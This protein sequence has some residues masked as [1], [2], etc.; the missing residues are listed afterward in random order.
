MVV[1]FPADATAARWTAGSTTSFR[2]SRG[3][4]HPWAASTSRRGPGQR[5]GPRDSPLA[6]AG[7]GR[8]SCGGTCPP[9]GFQLVHGLYTVRRRY[10]LTRPLGLHSRVGGGTALP[11]PALARAA[12]RGLPRDPRRGQV[13]V[14]VVVPSWNGRE[15]LS[16]LLPSLAAQTFRD[17]ETVVV[18]NGS[19]MGRWRTWR[20]SGRWCEVVALP[21]NLGFAGPVNRGISAARGEYVALVNNDV[22]LDPGFLAALVESLDAAPRV[23]SVASRMVVFSDRERMDGAGDQLYWSGNAFARGRGEPVTGLGVGFGGL[24]RV[25]RRGPVPAR[26]VRRGGCVRRG[27]LRLPGGRRLGLP[28]A[29]GRLELCVRASRDR[30]SRRWR[31]DRVQGRRTPAR[32]PLEPPQRPR[33]GPKGLPRELPAPLRA[34]RRLGRTPRARRLRA[35]RDAPSPPRGVR[36]RAPRPAA[37]APQAPR[38]PARTGGLAHRTRARGEAPPRTAPHPL[39]GQTL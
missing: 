33:D 6:C 10:K 27:L 19:S 8:C 20:V 17:F 37:H 1:T 32:L 34:P 9:N 29:P 39:K 30:V 12:R 21:G 26:R 16:V 24:Q 15:H 23:A 38:D 5:G 28:S 14:S 22:E 13:K 3:T 7:R 35:R 18:D 36:R 2:A 4:D 11:S 25:R 31:D